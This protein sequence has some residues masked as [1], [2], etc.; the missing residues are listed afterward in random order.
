[1]IL[2]VGV[3]AIFYKSYSLSRRVVYLVCGYF[4]DFVNLMYVSFKPLSVA[5]L[6]R[7]VCY[8]APY[9]DYS[10]FLFSMFFSGQCPGCHW[11]GNCFNFRCVNR[12]SKFL[13]ILLNSGQYFLKIIYMYVM[14]WVCVFLYVARISYSCIYFVACLHFGRY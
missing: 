1:M 12:L 11:F 5:F 8:F 13:Y 7:Y 6:T 10:V 9:F 4:V 3:L 14:A 2:F